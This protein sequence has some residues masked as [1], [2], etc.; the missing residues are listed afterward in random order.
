MHVLYLI[1]FVCAPPACASGGGEGD[2]PAGEGANSLGLERADYRVEPVRQLEAG[3]L[4]ARILREGLDGRQLDGKRGGLRSIVDRKEERADAVLEP[5]ELV[6]AAG[7]TGARQSWAKNWRGGACV[8]EDPWRM[9]VCGG[10]GSGGR[11]LS[12]R[13]N[14]SVSART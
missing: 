12:D 8:W 14:L 5:D 2:D 4:D 9:S 6:P 10:R 13:E 7:A 11:L 3:L 1:T